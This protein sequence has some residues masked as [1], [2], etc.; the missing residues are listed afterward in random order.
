MTQTILFLCPHHAA[1]S[2]IAAAYFN[3]LAQKQQVPF[4]ADSAG[5]EPDATVSPRVVELLREEGMD[6]SNHQPMRVTTEQLEQAKAIISMGC[7]AEELGV[8]EERLEFWNDVPMV[9]QDPNGAQ[10]TIRAH[11]EALLHQLA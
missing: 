5:T 8:A 10:A 4:I 6:V 9:S 7:T 2:V 1:K 3:Q 11:V